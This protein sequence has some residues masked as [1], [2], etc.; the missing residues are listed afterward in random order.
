MT[1]I[2]FFQDVVENK[3]SDHVS[4][5]EIKIVQKY[6]ALDG[7]GKRIVLFLLEEEYRRCSASRFDNEPNVDAALEKINE[8]I[9]DGM[10]SKKEEVK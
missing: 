6:R 7:H 2:I 1:R 9:G 3:F 5:D 10:V 8:N 4:P